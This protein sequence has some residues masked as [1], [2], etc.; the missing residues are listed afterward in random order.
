MNFVHFLEFCAALCGVF[1][2]DVTQICFR[3]CYTD[4]FSQM[5]H[6][7]VS[8]RCYTDLFRADVTQIG[9]RRCYTDLFS[10]MLR[11]FVFADVTQK[12]LRNICA[13]FSA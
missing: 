11:R 10:Q 3:R 12:N 9:F 13:F 5:L 6:R 4:L 8:R 2:A 7:F 1:R